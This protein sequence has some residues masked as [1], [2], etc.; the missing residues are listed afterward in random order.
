[1]EPKQYW[2]SWPS[3]PQGHHKWTVGPPDIKWVKPDTN[4]SNL[5][6]S[7]NLKR[8]TLVKQDKTPNPCFYF[9]MFAEILA[10]QLMQRGKADISD[11]DLHKLIYSM[12][13][14]TDLVKIFK[15]YELFTCPLHFLPF[16]SG[17]MFCV[18]ILTWTFCCQHLTFLAR[19]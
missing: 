17:S 5:R 14:K 11:H 10:K 4:N 19:L 9:Q 12:A 18:T 1:M 13:L 2:C 15:N 16:N 3:R 8:E 7:W 6:G